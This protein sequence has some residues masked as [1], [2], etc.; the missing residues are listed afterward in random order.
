MQHGVRQR[1][2]VDDPYLLQIACVSF[3]FW[4][5]RQHSPWEAGRS[6]VCN[7]WRRLLCFCRVAALHG[8]IDALYLNAGRQFFGK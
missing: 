3:E 6:V 2:V 1:L 7:E 4:F 5:L 8:R